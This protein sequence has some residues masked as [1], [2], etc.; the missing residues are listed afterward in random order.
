MIL[1]DDDDDDERVLVSE[2]D[3]LLSMLARCAVNKRWGGE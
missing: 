2:C 1:Y 3:A